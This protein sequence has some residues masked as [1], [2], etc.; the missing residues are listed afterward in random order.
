MRTKTWVLVMNAGEA[1]ILQGLEADA[2]VAHVAPETPPEMADRP[3]RSFA[4]DASGRRSAMEPGS[5]PERHAETGFARAVL[6]ELAAAHR[7]GR[8]E[9]L[10]ILAAPH[11]LGLLR[12]EMPGELAPAV[13]HEDAANLVGAGD[14]EIRDRVTEALRR[15][16]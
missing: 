11:M 2:P 15:G 16:S 8:F 12:A 14:G 4:S 5:D 10:A 13:A 1:R 6:A 9:R 3:G 7:A